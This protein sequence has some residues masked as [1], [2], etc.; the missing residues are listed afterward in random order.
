MPLSI[1]NVIRVTLLSALAGLE[2]VNTSALA[3]LTDEVPIPNDFGVFRTYL[4]AIGVSADFGS[5]SDTARL[6]EK[7]FSQVPNIL[8][9]KGYLVVIPREQDAATQ[10]ATIL[11]E[12]LVDFSGMTATDYTLNADVDAGPAADILIGAIDTT[13]LSTILTSLNNAAITGAGLI[14]TISGEVV[15]ARVTLLTI[16]TGAASTIAIASAITG[17]DISPLIQMAFATATGAAAGLERI[18]DTILR[19]RGSVNYFGIVLNAKQSDPFLLQIASFMQTLDKLLFIGSNLTADITGI[20]KT[21]KDSGYTH[22][23]CILYTQSE[24]EAFD[25]AAGYASRGLST[26]F[27]GSLTAQTMHLKEIV[28]FVAD[29]GITQTFLDSA[30]ANGVDIYVDFGIPKLFTSGANDYFDFIYLKLA[31][32]LRIQI[33]GFNFLAQTSTKIPQ[34]EA[35]MNGLKSE[36]RKVCALFVTNGNLA[37]GTW[38]GSTMFGTPEDHIRNISEQGYFVYS[39]P[40]SQQSQSEREARIA[41]L[42][43]IAAK[44]AGAIHSSDVVIFIEA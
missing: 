37:P 10:P 30:K 22:V 14:F 9:G 4:D 11:S 32:K 26:N 41:P 15:A 44:S 6:A 36:Y 40:I 39:I 8:T 31:L 18:K 34:T 7:I 19:T 17:T 38:T 16:S 33:A 21:I 28:G 29:N 23:R 25:F 12:S 13:D 1:S 2:N 20:F 35:G 27:D 42:V 5:N 3:I 24:S 43:Q